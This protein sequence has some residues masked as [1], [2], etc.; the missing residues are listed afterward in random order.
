MAPG[1]G[2][3]A[4]LIILS[5]IFFS[6]LLRFLSLIFPR[7]AKKIGEFVIFFFSRVHFASVFF[8]S[9]LFVFREEH[10]CVRVSNL[11]SCRC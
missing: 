6:L 11:D 9:F 8:S 3:R 10:C 1:G 2:R 5:I 4:R 7:A